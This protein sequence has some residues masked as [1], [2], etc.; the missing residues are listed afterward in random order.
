MRPDAK[1]ETTI[2]GK[3]DRLLDH[4]A[5][6]RWYLG[7]HRGTEVSFEDAVM[8]WYDTVYM[9]IVQVIREHDILRQFP[10]RTETDLY[11]WIVQR[12]WFLREAYG[13]EVPIEKATK[14]I[15]EELT[16]NETTSPVKKVI[17]AIKKAAGKK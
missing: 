12:Q 9:P 17:D 5:T 16:E 7:E 14:D 11:L 1:I 4:I 10:N 15:T 13:E 8:S 6:H 2:P 3:Y